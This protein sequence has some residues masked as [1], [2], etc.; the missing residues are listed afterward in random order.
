[1]EIGEI[2]EAETAEKWRGWLAANHALRRDIWLVF[3]RKSV[4]RRWLSYEQ[5]IEEALC[6]GWVDGQA[7]G[8]DEVR[9][10]IRFTPRRPGRPLAESNRQRALRLI[11]GGRMT[12][13]GAGVLP[14]D[15]VAIWQHRNG[16]G[17]GG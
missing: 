14:A 16:L 6:Y 9:H 3:F 7:K 8:M 17:D 13:A 11:D 1:V 5:A 10:A 2:L 15:L 4:G 12:E